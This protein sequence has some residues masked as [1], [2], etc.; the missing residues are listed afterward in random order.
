VLH[1]QGCI[2]D[3]AF[4]NRS[5]RA[6]HIFEYIH[7]LESKIARAREMLILHMRGDGI[8]GMGWQHQPLGPG[9]LGPPSTVFQGWCG[10]Q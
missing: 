7:H 2:T 1:R 9:H 10:A 4:H 5:G 8:G 3:I 6:H